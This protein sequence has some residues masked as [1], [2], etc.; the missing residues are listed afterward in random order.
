MYCIGLQVGPSFFQTFKKGGLGMSLLATL[1]VLL[2]VA[3]TLG[4]FYLA[5]N[6]GIFAQPHQKDNLA[7]MVGVEQSLTPPHLVLQIA[8]SL[9]SLKMVVRFQLLLMAT[10]VLIL[11]EL[12]VSFYLLWPCASSLV[13]L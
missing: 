6:T 11:L 10:L 8:S 5:D 3:M 4:L 12:L 9:N 13:S 7:M 1:L 2:N